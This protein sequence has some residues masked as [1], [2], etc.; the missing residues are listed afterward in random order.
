MSQ[1]GA[2]RQVAESGGPRQSR[3]P[4][5]ATTERSTVT[6]DN[7]ISTPESHIARLY[8]FTPQ[9]TVPCLGT[10]SSLLDTPR[11]PSWIE[12]RALDTIPRKLCHCSAGLQ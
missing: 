11:E 5:A 4:A 6:N 2:Y 8:N 10:H 12:G 9:R 1:R 3:V 7:S